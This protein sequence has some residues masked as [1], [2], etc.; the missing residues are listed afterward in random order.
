MNYINSFTVSLCAWIAILINGLVLFRLKPTQIWKE[1]VLISVFASSIS[2]ILQSANL[3]GLITVVPPLVVIVFFTLLT[4]FSWIQSLSMVVVCYTISGLLEFAV[5]LF[6]N[7]FDVDL[8][9][10]KL[11]DDYTM[12]SW[13]FVGLHYLF[14]AFLYK[15]RIGFTSIATMHKQKRPKLHG[16]WLAFLFVFLFCN[17]IAGILIAFRKTVILYLALLLFFMFIAYMAFQYKK[18][19]ED[20]FEF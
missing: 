13:Y 19:L 10:A 15:K 9:L 8:T 12:E 1:I 16:R 17:S 4:G 6:L 11:A 20:D 14:S 18:E 7:Q 2:L 3:I 5:T